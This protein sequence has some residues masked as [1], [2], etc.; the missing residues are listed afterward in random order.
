MGEEEEEKEDEEHEEA[1]IQ[2]VCRGRPAQGR[3]G[4]PALALPEGEGWPCRGKAAA[5]CIGLLSR[6]GSGSPLSPPTAPQ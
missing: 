6:Q 1:S 2:S 3:Q 4:G 5:A